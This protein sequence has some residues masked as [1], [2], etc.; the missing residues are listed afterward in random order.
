M[1]KSNEYYYAITDTLFKWGLYLWRFIFWLT[2]I[3]LFFF[4]DHLPKNVAGAVLV[5]FFVAL[6]LK[7]SGKIET[8]FEK[9]A[10]DIREIKDKLGLN[11]NVTSDIVLRDSRIRA[12][13]HD[14]IV[15]KNLLEI[16]A[17]IISRYGLRYWLTDGR[18]LALSLTEQFKVSKICPRCNALY[19]KGL[20][21]CLKCQAGLIH[22]GQLLE[23]RTASDYHEIT[24]QG[25]E[26]DR[27]D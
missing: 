9:L 7:I 2:V 26:G 6:F 21:E 13:N 3:L 10:N 15:G 1:S 23:I 14:L 17:D 20:K 5:L 12:I 16:R 25:R 22:T 18:A 8:Y 11:T 24:D 27:A 4:L 19:H